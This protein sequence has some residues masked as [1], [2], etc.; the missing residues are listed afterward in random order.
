MAEKLN[1]WVATDLKEIIRLERKYLGKRKGFYKYLAA[2]LN[3]CGD[4]D[5]KDILEATCFQIAKHYGQKGKSVDP[6]RII[7]DVTSS[8]DL[9]T[10]SRIGRAVR[11]A[12]NHQRNWRPRETLAR[13]LS[14]N[15]GIAGCA[16]KLAKPRE[17]YESYADRIDWR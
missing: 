12:F 10:R 1:L 8:A 2:L 13:F 15:G 6:L 5:Q 9:K 16:R 17:H 7:V 3:F 11:Y 4:L 14:E